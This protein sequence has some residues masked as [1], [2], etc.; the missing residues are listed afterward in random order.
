MRVPSPENQGKIHRGGLWS[1]RSVGRSGSGGSLAT[2]GVP[3]RPRG[4]STPMAVKTGYATAPPPLRAAK[5]PEC[6]APARRTAEFAVGNILQH[7]GKT[8]IINSVTLGSAR[9][10]VFLA[11]EKFNPVRECGPGFRKNLDDDK[12]G[13]C[14]VNVCIYLRSLLSEEHC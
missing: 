7:A 4:L 2:V 13:F 11:S 12:S 5:P 9:G 10:R 8:G 1:V 14:E 6:A 3:S